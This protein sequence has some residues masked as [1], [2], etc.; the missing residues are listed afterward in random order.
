MVTL[1]DWDAIFNQNRLLATVAGSNVAG[2]IDA[3]SGKDIS[4]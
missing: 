3:Q 1:E 4:I 2:F